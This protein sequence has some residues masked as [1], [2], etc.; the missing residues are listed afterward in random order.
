MI[1]WNGSFLKV[2]SNQACVLQG[3]A[4][5]RGGPRVFHLLF[6]DDTLI[7]CQALSEA[8]NCIHRILGMLEAASSLQV[9]L[10]K[11]LCRLSKNDHILDQEA[12][13]GILGVHVVAKHD[14]YLGM[15]VVVGRSK[16]KVFL[17]LKD[18]L[19]VRLQ[20]WKCVRKIHW[21]AWD[22]LCVH[23]E[24]E[25]LGFRK[26]N[27]QSCNA[28]KQL[29]RIV[30]RPNSLLNRMLKSKYFPT[31]DALTAPICQGCSFTWTSILEARS[32]ILLGSRWQLGDGKMVRIWD[33]RWIPRPITFRVITTPNQLP[34][35]A[36]VDS[37]LN[38]GG[39]VW[40]ESLVR[41]VF[42][43][44]ASD[45][46]GNLRWHY[47]KHRRYSVRSAYHLMVTE[48]GAQGFSGVSSSGSPSWQ[49]IWRPAVPPKVRLFAWKICREALSTTIGLARRGVLVG[50]G[51]P[52]CGDAAEDLLHACCAP[53]SLSPPGL[54]TVWRLQHLQ[55]VFDVRP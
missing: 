7:F 13:T 54:G 31:S 50:S 19:W 42:R 43:P 48:G 14:K 33:D 11:I 30:S 44:L 47:E 4:V 46:P 29:C 10:D 55:Q 5:S 24:E 26:L 20:S 28:R 6:A 8:M 49:F 16:R 21:I 39:E 34:L 41:N 53:F 1:E 38:E 2:L 15:R 23:K 17:N 40:N 12:L 37:L 35:N 45:R 22:K 3:V 18:R 51:S 25:G 9:N 52:W 32:V 36:T 27:F